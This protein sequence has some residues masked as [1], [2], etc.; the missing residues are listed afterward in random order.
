M[1]GWLAG[2]FGH[3]TEMMASGTLALAVSF[4]ILG[5]TS[6]P[7]W[8]TTALVGFS[9]SLVPAVLWPAVAELVDVRRLG[10]AFG[11]MSI[12]QEL[13]MAVC[14]LAVGWLNDWGHAGL[15]HPAGYLPMLWFFGVLSFLG[16]A[17]IAALWVRERGHRPFVRALP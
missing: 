8:V 4:L 16:F 15:G 11:L 12:L 5:A 17:L 9:Y 14:N 13:G 1:F 2:R 3:K 10:A 6:W 7:L